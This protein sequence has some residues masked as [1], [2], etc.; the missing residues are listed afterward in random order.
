MGTRG[1]L[2]FVADG[3][4]TIT[5]K[6][7]DSYP[8]GLGADVLEWARA[9]TDWDA[10]KVQAA[11]IVHVDDATA[12]PTVDQEANLLTLANY[13]VNTHTIADSEGYAV[14]RDTPSWYQVLHRTQGEPAAIL[15]AGHAVH[16]PEWPGDSLFCEWGYVVDMDA[17]VLEVYTGFQRS[18]H[19]SGRFA[20][21]KT[22]PSYYPIKLVATWPLTG[23]PTDD[24]FLATVDP[25]E[26]EE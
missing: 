9:I 7:F 24:E 2:G 17:M 4:E 3:K 14:P 15:R 25:T 11:A 10:V 22:D 26:D 16:V 21:R 8:A 13:T 18:P 1:M 23:L 20:D 12:P 19:T 6:Q 5:Y